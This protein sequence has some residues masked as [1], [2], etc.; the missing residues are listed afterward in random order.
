[1]RIRS[2]VTTALILSLAL[3]LSVPGAAQPSQ[4]DRDH[5]L[6]EQTPGYTALLGQIGGAMAVA[7]I[8]GG[9]WYTT[10]GPR[11]TAFDVT[12]PANPQLL[13]QSAMLHD[14]FG[15]LAVSGTHA[16]LGGTYSAGL[17]ILDVSDPSAPHVISQWSGTGGT[18]GIALSGNYAYLATAYG[19]SI[20]D[21]SVPGAPSQVGMLATPDRARD[22]AVRGGLAYVASDQAGL[23][24]VDI[25]D[26]ADPQP[27]V[28]YNPFAY[29][30]HPGIAVSGDYAYL[31]CGGLRIVR[32]STPAQPV[33]VASLYGSESVSDIVVADSL[34]FVTAGYDGL[35]IV[36]LS[37]PEHPHEAGSNLLPNGAYGVAVAGTT[38]CVA[39]EWTGLHVIDVSDPTD[40]V[41]VGRYPVLAFVDA[42]AIA[43]DYAYTLVDPLHTPYGA[44]NRRMAVIDVST[45]SAPREV[46]SYATPNFASTVAVSGQYLY[47]NHNGL[48]ILDVSQPLTPTLRGSCCTALA[49]IS[50]DIAIAGHYAYLAGTAFAGANTG[51]AIV[52]VADPASPTLVWHAS[53]LA[54]RTV[55]VTDDYAYLTIDASPNVLVFDVTTPVTPVL[56][57]TYH[58]TQ[59]ANDLAIAGDYAYVATNGGL[60][61]V[62]VTQPVTPALVMSIPGYTT[63]CLAVAGNRLYAG[64]WQTEIMNVRVFDLSDPRAPSEVGGYRSFLYPYRMAAAGDEAYVAAHPAGILILR[65]LPHQMY[66]PFAG[67]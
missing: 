21:V 7:A 61:V 39:D 8:Q 18:E 40:P 10:G 45:P 17:V 53:D 6:P 32:V 20:V 25:S 37:D 51:L 46:G 67:R 54:S 14:L 1:M 12:D 43:G 38:A 35:R 16:Y 52:D 29:S 62:D 27:L 48:E 15:A 47:I 58:A 5:R 42:I 31:N 66:L 33:L 4:V 60:D 34:G 44:T 36:D 55:A 28:T 30:C 3:A 22:V 23:R 50:D 64:E 57:T 26:P 63:V 19:L 49:G 65:Y 2:R 9:Y 24:I 41:R 11:L 59:V 56:V 13:G